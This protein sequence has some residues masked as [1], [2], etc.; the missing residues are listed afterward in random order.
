MTQE[1]DVVGPSINL[2]S[3][4]RLT[5]CVELSKSLGLL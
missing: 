2:V 3:M 4:V 1:Q 5:D